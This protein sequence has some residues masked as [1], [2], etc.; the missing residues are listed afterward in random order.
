MLLDDLDRYNEAGHRKGS[1]RFWKAMLRQAYTHPGLLAVVVY[2]FG[3]GVKRFRIPIFRQFLEIVYQLLYAAVRFGLQIE[4]PRDTRI[5]RG[6]RIDH[7]GSILVNSRAVIGRNFTLTQGVLVGE[8]ETGAPEIGDDVHCGVGCKII[9]GITLGD[10]VKIGAGTI[11]TRSFDGYAVI[12]GVPARIL[13]RLDRAPERSGWI[14]APGLRVEAH[15]RG[16]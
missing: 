14:P 10:C 12:A 6:L 16:E 15:R 2:R 13:R 3:G 7:Y 8:T 5:G 9:G 1:L 11:V 4:V